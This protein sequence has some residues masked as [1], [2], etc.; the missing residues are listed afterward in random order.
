MPAWAVWIILGIVLLGVEATTTAFVAIYFGV[1]A[2]LVSLLALAGLPLALQVVAFA[3]L[4]VAGLLLTR[5]TLARLSGSG[6]ELRIGAEALPGQ[7]GVVVRAIGADDP[8]QVRIGGDTWTA[9]CYFDD[10]AIAEGAR[11]EVIEVRGVT[12]LVVESHP[13]PKEIEP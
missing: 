9:R 5:S 6:P 12:A 13:S 11:V 4:S 7:R 1:A 8:G 10:E 2:L 3:G